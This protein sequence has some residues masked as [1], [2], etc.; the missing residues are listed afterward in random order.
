MQYLEDV[1][2]MLETY[3][4][5][6]NCTAKSMY[7]ILVS[8]EEVF[9]NIASYAY[10]SGDG[11]IEIQCRHEIGSSDDNTAAQVTFWITIKDW[12]RSYNPLEH[13]DPDFEIPFEERRIGGLG[14]YMVKQFMDYVEYQSADGCN[15]LTIGKKL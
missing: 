3:L 9:T 11:M 13:P 14:V 10:D 2:N 4:E 5:P 6:F 8:V 1:L 15:I 12:G 7:Q